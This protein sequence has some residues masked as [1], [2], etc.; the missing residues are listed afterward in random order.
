MNGDLLLIIDLSQKGS[1]SMDFYSF[2][3]TRLGHLSEAAFQL[4]WNRQ[5]EK[6]FN[7]LDHNIKA[8]GIS[9]TGMGDLLT[10]HHCGFRIGQNVWD[11][12]F[13]FP[14]APN[15]N[16]IQSLY[17]YQES[18]EQR[19]V[20]NSKTKGILQQPVILDKAI[21][22]ANIGLLHGCEEVIETG[23]Y[24]GGSS[25]IFSGS[26]SQVSTIEA[27]EELHK[28]AASWLAKS[29]ANVICHLGNSS[30]VLSEILVSSRTGK[31]LFFLDAH[32]SGGP[33]TGVYGACPLI[34]ELLVIT[35]LVQDYVI[36][37]DDARE[38]GRTIGYPSFEEI[39]RYLP[40]GKTCQVEHDQIIIW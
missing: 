38:M 22:A 5:Y 37:I 15:A 19:L 16:E 2:L 35:E 9:N 33:T 23:T 11:D 8:I 34:D 36:V 14:D 27:D 6:C 7:L 28:S 39:F 12:A 18:R 32:Y 17:T 30:K 13:K 31:K 20:K 1:N 29:T 24:L 3:K 26:F 10:W 4:F 21:L 40:R 25:Y